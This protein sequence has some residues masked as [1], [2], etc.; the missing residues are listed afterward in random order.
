MISRYT[1]PDMAGVWTDE[2]RFSKWLEVEIAV[3]DVLAERGEIPTE[4][5]ARIRQK[6]SFSVECIR[7]I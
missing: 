7:E 3:C 6:A 2:N 5:A 4:A 1:H